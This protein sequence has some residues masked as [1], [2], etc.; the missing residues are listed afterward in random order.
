MCDFTKKDG[1][2]SSNLLFGF[3]VDTHPREYSKINIT[4]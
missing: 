1:E 4:K 3:S 2:K